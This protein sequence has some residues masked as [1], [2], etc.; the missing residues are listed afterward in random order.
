MPNS[1]HVRNH[2]V[3]FL[4]MVLRIQQLTLAGLLL[5]VS[6][7]WLLWWAD[8]QCQATYAPWMAIFVRDPSSYTPMITDVLP[9]VH[10]RV[11]YWVWLCRAVSRCSVL[12]P[13][14]IWTANRLAAPVHRVH[15]DCC[16]IMDV[17][18]FTPRWY[19]AAR[20]QAE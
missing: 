14:T 5:T 18:P 4:K 12:P 13:W 8:P 3:C 16:S 19:E 20:R 6:S 10:V 1:K 11:W 7:N 17:T 2:A 9:Y 15:W